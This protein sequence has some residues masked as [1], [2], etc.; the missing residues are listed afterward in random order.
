M[1]GGW[2]SLS[3]GSSASTR[4]AF[5]PESCMAGFPASLFL[6]LAGVTLLFAHRRNERHT[7]GPRDPRAQRCARGSARAVRS[8]FFVIAVPAVVG[9]AWRRLD[10]RSAGA[11]GHAIGRACGI[12]AV[13]DGADGGQRRERR[14]ISRRFPRSASSRTARW[15]RPGSS[16]TKGGCG[17]P[18]SPRT[19]SSPAPLLAWLGCR[20]SAAGGRQTPC[21][22]THHLTRAFTRHSA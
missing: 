21:G 17:S 18:I 20:A 1:S 7:R 10:R 8:C 12:L 11:H 2:R 15:P 14:A 13:A 19:C 4:P 3:R 22:R 9:R 16:A 5:A 6:T